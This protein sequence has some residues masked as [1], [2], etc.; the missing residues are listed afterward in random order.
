M[1]KYRR[2]KQATDEYIIRR[3]PFACWITKATHTHSML[4]LLLFHGNNG[5]ANAPHTYLIV[6]VYYLSCC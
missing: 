1:E 6:S 2:A 5:F 4:H 3:M